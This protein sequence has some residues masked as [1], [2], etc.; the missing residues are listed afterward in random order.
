MLLTDVAGAIAGAISMS[1]G[2]CLATKSQDEVDAEHVAQVGG[3]LA[4]GIGY[5]FGVWSPETAPTQ[6]ANMC[7]QLLAL[8]CMLA[9][10]EREQAW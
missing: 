5:W 6:A 2:E 8:C 9:G 7:L 4:W 1:A 3:V 10:D